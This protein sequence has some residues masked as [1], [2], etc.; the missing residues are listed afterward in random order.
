MQP[1]QLVLGGPLSEPIQ[2]WNWSDQ[3]EKNLCSHN[4]AIPAPLKSIIDNVFF[5]PVSVDINIHIDIVPFFMI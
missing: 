4:F 1:R 2:I 5:I 3:W